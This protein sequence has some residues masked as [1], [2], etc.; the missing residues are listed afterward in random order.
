LQQKNGKVASCVT[1]DAMRHTAN[2][3]TGVKKEQ[4]VFAHTCAYADASEKARPEQQC[5]E[6]PS[7]LR[8]F[9]V[10]TLC[11]RVHCDIDAQHSECVAYRAT[12]YRRMRVIPVD[13]YS[14]NR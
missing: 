4:S 5:F 13:R 8:Q 3:S 9:V 11:T 12:L 10:I 6:D 1:N 14:K 7:K 2:V